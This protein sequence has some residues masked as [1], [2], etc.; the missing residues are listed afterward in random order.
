MGSFICSPPF[1]L[2]TSINHKERLSVNGIPDGTYTTVSHD[3][4]L[5][6]Q[7]VGVKEL[8]QFIE[9]RIL[10]VYKRIRNNGF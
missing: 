1:T 6:H 2:Y 8:P 5:I 9:K 3:N 10:V 7:D 4:T